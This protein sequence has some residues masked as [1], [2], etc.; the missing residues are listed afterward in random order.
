MDTNFIEK[1]TGKPLPTDSTRAEKEFGNEMET[2]GA[3]GHRRGS[4][5]SAFLKTRTMRI[6]VMSKNLIDF[7]FRIRAKL[8]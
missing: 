8:T 2:S 6:E 1:S 7:Y 5:T 3:N 4:A